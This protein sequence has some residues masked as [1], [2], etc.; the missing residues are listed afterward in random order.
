MN[1][2][3][4]VGHFSFDNNATKRSL[5]NHKYEKSTHFRFKN[6]SYRQF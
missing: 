6:E 2:R 3:M 1:I 5:F 4:K